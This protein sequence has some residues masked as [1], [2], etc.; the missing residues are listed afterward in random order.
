MKLIDGWRESL[1]KLWSIRVALFTALLGSAD[2]IL[3]I[4]VSVIPPFIYSLL[5]LAIIL[6]RIIDQL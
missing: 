4:W 5:A 3:Q 6:A 2:Q 1:N